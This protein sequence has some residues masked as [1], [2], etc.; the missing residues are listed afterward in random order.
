MNDNV[1]PR[2]ADNLNTFMSKP[3]S[4]LCRL[5]PILNQLVLGPYDF[6][7]LVF[8][9]PGEL[10]QHRIWTVSTTCRDS[11]RVLAPWGVGKTM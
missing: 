4:K 6:Q 1:F 2:Y 7:I 8:L 9:V 10:F 3:H 11:L 5:S